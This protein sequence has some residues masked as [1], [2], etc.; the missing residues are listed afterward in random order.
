MGILISGVN[1][2]I[3]DRTDQIYGVLLEKAVHI[4][5]EILVLVFE[6]DLMLADAWRPLYQVFLFLL[7]L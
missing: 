4:S 2:L 7:S 1:A 6:K 3:S 5:L